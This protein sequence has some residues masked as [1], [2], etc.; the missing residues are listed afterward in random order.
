MHFLVQVA[1]LVLLYECKLARFRMGAAHH[2]IYEVGGE[3]VS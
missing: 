3:E 1:L 2:V